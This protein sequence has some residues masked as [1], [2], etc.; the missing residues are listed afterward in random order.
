MAGVQTFTHQDIED[1]YDQTENHYR[2]WWSLSNSLGLHYGVWDDSTK[3]IAEAVM[4]L[5]KML[6]QLAEIEPETRVL[7]AGCGIGGSSFFLAQTKQCR[8]TGVTLSK[9]QVESASTYAEKKG[10]AEQCDF[11]RCSYTQTPFGVNT[12]DVSWAIESLG[13]ANN[14]ADFFSEMQRIIKPHGKIAIADTFKSYSYPIEENTTMQKML[15]PWAISDILS[16]EELIEIAKAHGFQ[17][18]AKNDVTAQIKK[19]VIR[20]YWAS[21]AGKIATKAYNLFKNATPF[22]KTHYKSGL[23]QKKTYDRG[24]WKYQLFVFEKVG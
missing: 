17:L 10:L 5:N 23:A 4:N 12:F 22:S 14:K 16:E 3:T 11:L 20:M 1:Y 19:S 13:S 18:I 15:N 2:T 24:D 7:D 8:T 9:K 21:L 6:S